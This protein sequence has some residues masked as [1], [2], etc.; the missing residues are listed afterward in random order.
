MWVGG[1][2]F[3]LASLSLTPRLPSSRPNRLYSTSVWSICM[4]HLYGQ[5][6]CSVC[7]VRPY[8]TFVSFVCLSTRY[9]PLRPGPLYDLTQCFQP[10]SPDDMCDMSV[11]RWLQSW[12]SDRAHSQPG[13][14]GEGGHG[15]LPLYSS[16]GRH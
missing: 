3:P 9:K 4:I 6:V 16:G 14:G 15:G 11:C 1:V 12:G 13:G 10:C 2:T 7:T 5:S 8:S